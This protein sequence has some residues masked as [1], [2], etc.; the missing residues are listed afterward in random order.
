[1]SQNVATGLRA[2]K[3]RTT[4]ERIAGEA[5][6]LVAG[7]GLTNTT[8]EQIAAAADV[9]RATFFRYFDTK[10]GAVAAGFAGVW[11]NLITDTIARQPHELSPMDAVRSAFAS[12]ARLLDEQKQLVLLQAELS[13]TSVTLEA[14]TLHLYV[15]FET[16]IAEIV[17]PRFNDLVPDDP[18][19]RLVGA[20]TMAVIRLSLDRWVADGGHG[21]LPAFIDQ[22]L[23]SIA[24]QPATR[25]DRPRTTG[26]G[27]AQKAPTKP[28]GR[29]VS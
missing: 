3:R 6:R 21:D 14:W 12:L 13:R 15:G 4:H 28:P 9:G 29:E 17:T 16:A 27:R 11:T 10:E 7:Q 23:R 25:P 19:P 26:K 1:M 8:V 20:L 22:G 2:R 18:R 5:A 24:V